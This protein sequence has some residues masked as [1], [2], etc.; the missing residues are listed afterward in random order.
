MKYPLDCDSPRR[1]TEFLYRAQEELRLLHNAFSKWLHEGLT[2]E[3]YGLLPEIVKSKYL[4]VSKLPKLEWDR[5]QE[6]DFTP[7]SDRICQEICV[8]RALLKKSLW[9]V[10]LGDM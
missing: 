8:Q 6:E 2:K 4:Y 5:F 1:R 7:R 9:S 3:Q 10:D